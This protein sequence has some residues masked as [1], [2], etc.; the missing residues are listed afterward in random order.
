MC[1][2]CKSETIIY[3]NKCQKCGKRQLSPFERN[4]MGA[5]LFTI[6]GL[7]LLERF[8]NWIFE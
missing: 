8:W 6:G 2:H 5:I 3:N 1:M 4:P 7:I